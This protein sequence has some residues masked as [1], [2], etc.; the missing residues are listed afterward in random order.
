[1]SNRGFVAFIAN[2]ATGTGR[3]LLG[4]QVGNRRPRKAQLQEER[5]RREGASAGAR[6]S[7]AQR[8]VSLLPNTSP[9]MAN[10]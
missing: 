4:A 10:W 8:A 9:P 7:T 5:G 1:M 2:G 3:L 6:R